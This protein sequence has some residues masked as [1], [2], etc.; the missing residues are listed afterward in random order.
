[1][2]SLFVFGIGAVR[3]SEV[4]ISVEGNFSKERLEEYADRIG[5]IFAAE[6][7][8]ERSMWEILYRRTYGYYHDEEVVKDS[9]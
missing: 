3:D 1:M 6:I 9:K 2:S 4:K 7:P 5:D 8:E